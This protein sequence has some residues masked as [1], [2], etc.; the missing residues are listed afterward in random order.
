MADTEKRFDISCLLLGCW[1][2]SKPKR[3]AGLPKR[4]HVV[5]QRSPAVGDSVF[6]TNI[7]PVLDQHQTRPSIQ[8]S[9]SSLGTHF[10]SVLF[11]VA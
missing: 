7:G 9:H 3:Q 2:T 8:I 4:P 5:E 11:M 1:S 10:S 6:R